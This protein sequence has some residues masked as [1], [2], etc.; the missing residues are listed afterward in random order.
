MIESPQLEYFP[1]GAYLF[2]NAAFAFVLVVGSSEKGFES[3]NEHNPGR[4]FSLHPLRLG[5]AR[6]QGPSGDA[7]QR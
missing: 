3:Q 1:S 7:P 5:W 4:Y 2:A 6:C